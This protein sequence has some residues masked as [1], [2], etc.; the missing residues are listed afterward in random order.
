MKTFFRKFFLT[1]TCALLAF[2][3]VD[4]RAADPSVEE[5]LADLEAYVNNS[6]RATASNT[7]ATKRI[8]LHLCQTVA[9]EDFCASIATITI[10]I[11]PMWEKFTYIATG[12]LIFYN[13][14]R[15]QRSR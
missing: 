14:A 13:D 10:E 12:V 8:N 2:S 11:F 4:T 5:R 7:H 3:A 6:V 1:L 15:Q 9:N